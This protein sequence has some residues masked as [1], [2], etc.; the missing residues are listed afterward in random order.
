MSNIKSQLLHYSAKKQDA[1]TPT[2]NFECRPEALTTNLK[3]YN[4]IVN[5][6]KTLKFNAVFIVLLI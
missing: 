6:V 5:Y 4:T 1:S 2:K 3:N